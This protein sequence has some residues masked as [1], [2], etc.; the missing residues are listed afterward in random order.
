MTKLRKLSLYANTKRLGAETT[1]VTEDSRA[2]DSF[3][4]STNNYI[5]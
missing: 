4:Y 5:L 3:N 2:Q 1:D